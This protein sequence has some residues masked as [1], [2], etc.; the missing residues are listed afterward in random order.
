[1]DIFPN[2]LYILIT[3][4]DRYA[5]TCVCYMVFIIIAAKGETVRNLMLNAYDLGLINGSY[6]FFCIEFFKQKDTF[7]D[8][9]WIS[10]DGRNED[11]KKAYEAL[12]KLSFYKPANNE[13]NKFA[14]EVKLRSKAEFGYEYGPDEEVSVLTAVAHDTVILY[15]IALNETLSEGG[16]PYNGTELVSRLYGRTFKGIQGNVTIDMSGDR[17]ADFMMYDMTDI[18]NG[19]FEVVG[20]YFGNRK[21]Y[22]EVEGRPI[23]WPGGATG[24]PED[25]PEC[26]FHGEYCPEEEPVNPMYV[27]ASIFAV[28]LVVLAVIIVVM[29]RKYKLQQAVANM[30]WRIDFDDLVLHGMKIGTTQQTPLK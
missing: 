12:F 27:V 22:E 1:M 15:A 23:H 24:P 14:D 19:K 7:G 25:E 21:V 4:S 17:D 8:F 26:G 3:F 29:Y 6:A 2:W 9:S 30:L 16:D 13:F 18:E 20:N 5:S 11:A 28:C 10:Q